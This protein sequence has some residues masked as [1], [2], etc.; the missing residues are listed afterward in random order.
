M[1]DGSINET[2]PA[3]DFTNCPYWGQ[4]GRYIGDPVTGLR[5]R[6]DDAPAVDAP[7][8]DIEKTP[9]AG[10]TLTADTTATIV[11]GKRNG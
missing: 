5:V 8:D 7:A 1:N 9:V 4:G 10:D 2:K 3:P 6:V 11:K